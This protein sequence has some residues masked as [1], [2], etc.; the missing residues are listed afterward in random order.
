MN[1]KV[2]TAFIIIL[3]CVGMYFLGGYLIVNGLLARVLTTFRPTPHYPVVLAEYKIR[4]LVPSETSPWAIFPFEIS[5]EYKDA[6][7]GYGTGLMNTETHE[8]TVLAPDNWLPRHTSLFSPDGKRV[9]YVVV[10]KKKI[11]ANE[12][13]TWRTVE[14]FDLYSRD[15]GAGISKKIMPNLT[16]SNWDTPLFGWINNNEVFYSCASGE[17]IYNLT[18]QQIKERAT[19]IDKYL[20]S[21]TKYQAHISL[22][23]SMEYKKK[24]VLAGWDGCSYSTL[25]LKKGNTSEFLGN[26]NDFGGDLNWTHGNHLYFVPMVWGTTQTKAGLIQLR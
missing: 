6:D 1:K 3:V 20:S 10:S 15:L 24:C 18:S 17:C 19:S 22:D 26:S 12:N 23:G 4:A 14:A 21:R 13:G 16:V 9:L 2:I 11:Y 5:K 7:L 25:N 8:V